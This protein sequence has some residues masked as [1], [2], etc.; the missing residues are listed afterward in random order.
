[1]IG[2]LILLLIAFALGMA[3]QRANRD[4]DDCNTVSDAVLTIV[5]IPKLLFLSVMARAKQAQQAREPEE[6]KLDP[7]KIDEAIAE[8]A[9]K[10][11][12]AE[13]PAA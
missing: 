4:E 6:P 7:A 2:K 12:K 8:R 11:A 3:F 9:K 13:T 5:G 1:M 10:R